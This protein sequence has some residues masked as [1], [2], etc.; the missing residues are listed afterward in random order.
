MKF[1][2]VINGMF[3]GYS[4]SVLLP[5]NGTS[6]GVVKYQGNKVEF[7]SQARHIYL[8]AIGL[9]FTFKLKLNPPRHQ[10]FFIP[11]NLSKNRRCLELHCQVES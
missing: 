9:Y 3:S 6:F 1:Q 4:F 2:A 11:F 7:N 10:V 5:Q 8:K